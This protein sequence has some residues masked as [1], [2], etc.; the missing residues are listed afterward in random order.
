[1]LIFYL[2]L[3]LCQHVSGVPTDDGGHETDAAAYL[4]L[5]D[6][7]NWTEPID[8][9]CSWLAQRVLAGTYQQTA[10]VSDNPYHPRLAFL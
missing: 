8:P 7:D 1:M 3:F 5:T 2:L 9:F 4:S 10:P 6:L